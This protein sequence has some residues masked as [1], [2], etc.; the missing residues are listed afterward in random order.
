MVDLICLDALNTNFLVQNWVSDRCSLLY[1]SY[2]IVVAYKLIELINEHLADS[3]F[4][5]IDITKR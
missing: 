4:N 2:K 5:N 3:N 1:L